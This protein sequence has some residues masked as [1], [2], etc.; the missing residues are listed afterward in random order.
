MFS[1]AVATVHLLVVDLPAFHRPPDG[2]LRQPIRGPQAEPVPGQPLERRQPGLDEL[3]VIL[4]ERHR[5]LDREVD[6]H[7]A[8]DLFEPLHPHDFAV[9]IRPLARQMDPTHAHLPRFRLVLDRQ[10]PG[11][12]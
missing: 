1:A 8:Q 7:L 6:V 3:Q 2:E 4:L 5:A 10:H 9:R 11:E 12:S